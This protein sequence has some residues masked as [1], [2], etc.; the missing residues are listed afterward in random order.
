MALEAIQNRRL[1]SQIADQLADLIARGTYPPGDYLPPERELAARLGVSRSSVR[2]ALIALEVMGLVD[3]RVGDGVLVLK[4]L[5]EE[6]T[7]ESL[8]RRVMHLTRPGP[9]PELPVMLDLDVEI[10]PF[11]LLQ[12]RRLVE[13]EAAARAATRATAA[14]LAAIEAALEQNRADNRIGSATHPG[15]RLF[16]I[17]IAAASGNAAYEQFMILLLG[18]RYGAM[19]QRLQRLYSSTDM[20]RRSEREHEAVFEAIRAG[21]AEAARG[22]MLHHLDMVIEIFSRE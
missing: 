9:D 22:A 2:E 12:A 10:P 13:P 17:R 20:P 5:P 6:A 21:D 15:D 14:Q 4:T 8:M 19:F 3:V 16:H 7:K 11:A 1:Y 18:H